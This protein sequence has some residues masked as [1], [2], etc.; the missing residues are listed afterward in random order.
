MATYLPITCICIYAI[1]GYAYASLH[2]HKFSIVLGMWQIQVIH[3][4][5][6]WNFPPPN[7]FDLLVESRE[8]KSTDAEG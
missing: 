4:R 7:I 1:A 3:F 2:L 6:F 5:T 8:A